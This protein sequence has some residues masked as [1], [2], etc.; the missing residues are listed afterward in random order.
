MTGTSSSGA[1]NAMSSS[2]QTENVL[3]RSSEDV[4]WEYGILA[5][6]TNSDKM[7][8]AWWYNY[9]N[10]VPN[11]QRMAIKILSLTTSSSGCERNWSSFEDVNLFL[12]TALFQKKMF[13]GRKEK[14]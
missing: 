5:N 3:K 8:F 6:P 9:G 1:S 13:S 2:S 14:V 7:K 10:G 12:R 11:L 4:G